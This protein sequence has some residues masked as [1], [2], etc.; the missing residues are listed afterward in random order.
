MAN[1]Y[2]ENRR[3]LRFPVSIPV[4]LE[5]K[6]EKL[7]TICSNI[8]QKGVYLETSEKLKKGD[9]VCLNLSLNPKGES[10]KIL[11]EVVWT[12]K[13]SSTDYTNKPITGFGIRFLANMK[14]S[15]NVHD[16]ILSKERWKP[17]PDKDIKEVKKYSA[18][19]ELS[20]N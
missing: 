17:S 16:G 19:S 1:L 15:L 10:A 5:D 18:K 8:S 20:F 9:V 14:D 12:F 2:K 11:G 3:F 6:E 4:N 13:T 7:S